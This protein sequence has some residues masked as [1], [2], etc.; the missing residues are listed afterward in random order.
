[1]GLTVHLLRHGKTA[2]EE[3]WRFLGQR[4]APLS[5]AG[6][7]QMRRWRDEFSCLDFAGAWC[8]DLARCRESAE[9][10]LA[11]RGLAATPVPG[12]REISLGEWDGLSV[13]E[14]RRGYPG[15]YEARGADIA[16]F[17][18][19]GGESFED[20]ALRA[21]QALADILREAAARPAGCPEDVRSGAGNAN[22]LLVAHAGVNRALICGLLGLPLGRLFNLG[23][24][25]GCLNVLRFGHGEP[26]LHALNR[27]A[28]CERRA[29]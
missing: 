25:H 21:G 6:R 17:R 3:P 26:V 8:S 23:Q 5:D 29:T 4:D 27:R 13:E 9:L 14:V 22:I 2:R 12:L 20:L 11:G 18:P 10:V 19:P 7:E 28:G 1:M 24:D 16:G 15:L